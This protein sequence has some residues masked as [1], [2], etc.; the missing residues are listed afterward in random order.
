MQFVQEV[1]ACHEHKKEC[2]IDV[3]TLVCRTF[4]VERHICYDVY[5]FFYRVLDA[6]EHSL[7]QGVSELTSSAFISVLTYF[8]HHHLMASPRLATLPSMLYSM[9]LV[10]G[11]LP[12]AILASPNAGRRHLAQPLVANQITRR[13]L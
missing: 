11:R 1:V 6:T 13:T 3:Q 2:V 12:H 5:V 10:A 4:R 9:N 7:L 8:L